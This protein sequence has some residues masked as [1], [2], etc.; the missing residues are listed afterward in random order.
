MVVNNAAFLSEYL[1]VEWP[2]VIV[3]LI[4]LA[5]DAHFNCKMVWLFFFAI[6]SFFIPFILL[7][8]Y[9]LEVDSH[10]ET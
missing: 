5:V 6:N 3:N 2:V 7:L 10:L 9:G 4:V 8:L 1:D